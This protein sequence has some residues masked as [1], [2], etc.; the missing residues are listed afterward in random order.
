[1][2]KIKK[3]NS[4]KEY[5]YEFYSDRKIVEARGPIT[6]SNNTSAAPLVF[7]DTATSEEEA[8]KKVIEAIARGEIK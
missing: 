5:F 2:T 4:G 1:M 3:S 7:S 6:Y 8:E